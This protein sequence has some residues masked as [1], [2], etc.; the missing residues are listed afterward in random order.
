MNL[1]EHLKNYK[2]APEKGREKI[3]NERQSIVKQFYDELEPQ[4]KK[5]NLYR[6]WKW[7]GKQIH[8]KFIKQEEWNTFK[9]DKTFLKHKALSF[10]A[11]KMSHLTEPTMK[12]FY[13]DCKRASNFSAYWWSSLSTKKLNKD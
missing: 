9:K 10:Y 7:R 2:I 1:S 8:P 4:R 13:V 5:E 12:L 11:Y 6:F 3:T